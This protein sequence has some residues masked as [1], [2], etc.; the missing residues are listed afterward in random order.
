MGPASPNYALPAPELRPITTQVFNENPGVK[1]RV[2]SPGMAMSNRSAKFFAAIFRQHFSGNQFRRRGGG[3]RQGR[4]ERQNGG[5]M[6]VRVRK[7][8]CRRAVIGI[9][10]SITPP[11]ASAGTSAKRK[12]KSARAAPKDYRLQRHVVTRVTCSIGLRIDGCGR[13]RFAAAEHPC[14]QI[15]RRCARRTDRAAGARRG[16]DRAADHR[17]RACCRNCK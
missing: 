10:A 14:A 15:D 17:C 16:S 1:R 4:N 9:T 3:W 12:N 11:S 7:G 2:S 8:L 6:S 5:R 13:S